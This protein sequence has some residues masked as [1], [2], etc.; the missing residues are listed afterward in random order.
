VCLASANDWLHGHETE[1]AAQ[2]SKR[3]LKQ[4]ATPAQLNYLPSQY[5]ND[6]SLTR[7]H[8]SCLL[9]FKFNKKDIQKYVFGASKR[10][11]NRAA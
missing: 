3:W 5:R 2:K 9:A 11:G 6:Y 7:Y 10:C 8:A 4:P 1:D